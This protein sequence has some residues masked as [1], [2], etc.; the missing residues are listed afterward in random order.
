MGA[1]APAA[2]TSEIGMMKSVLTPLAALGM[3]VKDIVAELG[4]EVQDIVAARARVP[5]AVQMAE[6]EGERRRESNNGAVGAPA[7][8]SPPADSHAPSSPSSAA[9]RAPSEC[10]G[11][12]DTPIGR[13]LGRFAEANS[14]VI[15]AIAQRSAEREPPPTQTSSEPKQTPAPAPRPREAPS[16]HTRHLRALHALARQFDEQFDALA[17]QL[18]GPISPGDRTAGRGGEDTPMTR[19][20]RV[21]AALATAA[22]FPIRESQCLGSMW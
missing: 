2:R 6:R 21:E 17:V 13:A 8:A 1:Y 7:H 15:S 4:V 9:F 5:A 19:A 20:S 11:V 14:A 10:E 22:S 3:E 12:E 18:G 16:S